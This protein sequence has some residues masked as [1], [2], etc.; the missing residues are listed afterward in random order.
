MTS[1]SLSS[2]ITYIYMLESTKMFG[3]PAAQRFK[4]TVLPLAPALTC[5]T[6]GLYLENDIVLKRQRCMSAKL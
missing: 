6:Y 4:R 3:L 5:S 2:N 1:R